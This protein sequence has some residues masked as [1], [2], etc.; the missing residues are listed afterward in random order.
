MPI[1]EYF[2]LDESSSKPE[3][4]YPDPSAIDPVL[5]AS[6]TCSS[7]RPTDDGGLTGEHTCVMVRGLNT[8]VES[9][10]EWLRE[11]ARVP[12]HSALEGA[13]AGCKNEVGDKTKVSYTTDFLFFQ[14]RLGDKA[15]L[16]LPLSQPLASN[17]VRNISN[18]LVDIQNAVISAQIPEA[19]S[20]VLDKLPV[21]RDQDKNRNPTP[22]HSFIFGY[23]IDDAS[24]DWSL[25]EAQVSNNLKGGNGSSRRL[26]GVSTVVSV[27]ATTATAASAVQKRKLEESMDSGGKDK[28]SLRGEFEKS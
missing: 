11:F 9:E 3:T 18:R 23:V 28:K 1:G 27:K 16:H 8:S 10:L 24:A 14:K 12:P 25:V 22:S 5:E 13:N 15:E 19:T 21:R 6:R 26:K 2:N 7:I 17:V 4:E 20:T